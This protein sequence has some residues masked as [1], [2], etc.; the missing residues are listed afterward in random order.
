MWLLVIVVV[1]VAVG[2]MAPRVAERGLRIM[3]AV[4]AGV[5]VV[6]GLGSSTL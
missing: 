5:V 1:A 2:L 3:L 6:V 4:A